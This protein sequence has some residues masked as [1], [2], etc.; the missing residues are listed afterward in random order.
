MPVFSAPKG[1]IDMITATLD[2]RSA[3]EIADSVT[4]TDRNRSARCHV[5]RLAGGGS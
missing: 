2:G 3:V 5:P 4:P 1:G